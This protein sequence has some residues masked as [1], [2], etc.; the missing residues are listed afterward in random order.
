MLSK[1][2]LIDC[3]PNSDCE[4]GG[5]V[6]D[7]IWN[8]QVYGLPTA[9]YYPYKAEKGRCNPYVRA[10]VKITDYKDLSAKKFNTE[11]ALTQNIELLEKY[12]EEGPIVTSMYAPKE[13]QFYLYGVFDVPHCTNDKELNH[14]VVIVGHFKDAWIIRGSE[15]SSWGLQGHF[16]VKKGRCGVGLQAYGGIVIAP[17]PQ[18]N[19]RGMQQGFT[20]KRQR[21]WT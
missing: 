18:D 16:L 13:T 14:E 2:Y 21:L 11:Q 10:Y 1:Q 3:T 8:I 4:N 20:P 12:L 9:H 15:T 17:F 6:L 19:S 7:A 5:D